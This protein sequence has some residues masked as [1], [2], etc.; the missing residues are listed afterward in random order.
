MSLTTPEDEKLLQYYSDPVWLSM[1]PLNSETILDYFSL[2][3][4]YDQT[5]CN[6]V[7]KMQ[8]FQD[9]KGLQD[10]T[11]V[12]YEVTRAVVDPKNQGKSV[13]VIQEQYRHAP[14]EPPEIK[15]VYYCVNG[16]FYQAPTLGQVIDSRIVC[17]IVLLI[18]LIF[19]YFFYLLFFF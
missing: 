3:V 16:T 15:A 10:M 5:S 13:F 7:L 6:A 19:F 2:S 18:L 14:G 4:F 8:G 9:L 17:N 12:Q 11:G 1:Y